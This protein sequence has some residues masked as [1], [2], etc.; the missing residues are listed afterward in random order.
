MN[1]LK[2][3]VRYG[4]LMVLTV[5]FSCVLNI[6]P[7]RAADTVRVGCVDIGNFIQMGE[8]GNVIGYGAEYLYK[9]A[10]YAGWEYE[11]VQAPWEECL[12]MLRRGEID[13]LLPA[14]YSEE[15]AQ[16]F[17]F[18]SYECCFD[19]AALVGRKSDSRLYYDDYEGFQG[20]RVGMIKGN[21][22]NGLFEEYSRLHGFTY[23]PMYYDTGTQIVDALEQGKVDAVI[24]GNMEYSANQKLLAKIDYMPAYF[25]TSI[26]KPGLM[27]R[28]DKALKKI[29]M[30][31]P[32]YTAS[33]YN[34]Y[35][36]DIDSQFS[37]FT[38]EESNFIR[39]SGPVTVMVAI[40]DYP[41][42]WYDEKSRTCRGAYVDYM[43]YLGTISGLRFEFLPADDGS[44]SREQVGQGRAQ[45][46][47]STF[48]HRNGRTDGN[49]S[50]TVPY[51][52]CTF[53][54]VGRKD[55]ALNL[56]SYQRIA[57]VE[58]IEGLRDV[59]R[60]KY[61]QWEILTYDTPVECLKAVENGS[62]D[63]AMVSSLKLSADR[64]MMGASLLVIDGST[65][66]TS[67]YMGVSE[68]ADPRLVQILSKSIAKAG[69]SPMDEAVYATLLSA[70]ERKDLS[71]IVR[72]YPLYFAAGV[73]A[74]SLMAMGIM[75]MRYDSRHQKIQNQ[76]LQRKN[77]E[78][79][80]AIAMQK[81]LRRKAQTDALTGLK[82]KC[83]TEE[84]C[85][86]CMDNTHGQNCALFILD[87]D[88]FKHINDERGHQA[89]DTVLRA[90]GTTLQGCVRQDDI[91]GRIGGDEFMLFMMGVRD[92][93]QL[94][95][96]ARR[97][98]TALDGNGEFDA[99]CSMGIVLTRSGQIP[100]EEMFQLADAALY[101]AK[102][103][104]KNKHYIE[105]TLERADGGNECSGTLCTHI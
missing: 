71:Y 104:G 92:E 50:Y 30:D 43:K 69:E 72:T 37:E 32:Y 74:L 20:I 67:V 13:L 33:L 94:H 103:S 68:S 102:A 29:F 36:H 61:P 46:L 64:N 26:D 96:F 79:K 42:E 3:R 89:G 80:A 76:I 19:F 101:K 28:L 59:L 90:F 45:V 1:S 31:D 51:Y 82:N 27:K 18:S 53:S 49:L 34:K 10:G 55:A 41:F 14:E 21:Y 6:F 57:V 24:N 77:D 7:V 22:L 48:N 52:N 63:C 91:A 54:L 5:L 35:Y 88:D 25:I 11:F 38:R 15:R 23:E 73:V 98:Y 44:S 93:E 84:L 85:R 9:I 8:D 4:A 86:A 78:L 56:S 81:L 87:L 12:D 2:G 17:L 83:T 66:A 65:A 40:N 95:M 60:E 16:D 97:I 47:L 105:N 62:A 99:T 100:Y 58:K 70:K 75:F 39:D